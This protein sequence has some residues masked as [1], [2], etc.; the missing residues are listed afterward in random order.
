MV[1]RTSRDYRTVQR[2][3]LPLYP[4]SRSAGLCSMRSASP[5]R[6]PDS[7]RRSRGAPGPLP[8]DPRPHRH[9]QSSGRSPGRPGCRRRPGPPCRPRGMVAAGV[10]LETKRCPFPNPRSSS[11]VIRKPRLAARGLRLTPCGRVRCRGGP[12]GSAG[13]RPG[14]GSRSSMSTAPRR[15][16]SSTRLTATRRR[17]GRPTAPN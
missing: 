10:G 1:L 8:V 4:R 15:R 9:R 7:G 16:L 11:H 6:C 17:S 3:A 2:S 12:R 14:V 13:R 5:R